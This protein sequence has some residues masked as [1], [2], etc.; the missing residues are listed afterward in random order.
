[1]KWP[2]S[3]LRIARSLSDLVRLL[4]L[5]GLSSSLF[6]QPERFILPP[7]SSVIT[8]ATQEPL[9]TL[10]AIN[11]RN[12]PAVFFQNA[13]GTEYYS[14]VRSANNPGVALQ[15]L[16][17]SVATAA[18][19]APDRRRLL[20]VGAGGLH[21]IDTT[22]DAAVAKIP[23]AAPIDLAA[24]SDGRLG[25]VLSTQLL[26]IDLATNTVLSSLSLAAGASA[27]AVCHTGLVYVSAPSRLYEINGGTGQLLREIPVPGSPGRLILTPNAR[28]TLAVNRA[29]AS[30]AQTQAV[31]EVTVAPLRFN[32]L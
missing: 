18:V 12:F 4:L 20:I 7:S 6:A 22:T 19:L 15:R 5:V 29:Y 1:M 8:P 13:E 23:V 27:V 24:S 17:L 14:I 3:S 26:F 9:T 2:V 30:S 11:T 16:N 25:Y 32:L 28:T 21:V 10:P 31:Y